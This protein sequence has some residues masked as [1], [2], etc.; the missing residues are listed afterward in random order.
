MLYK[1]NEFKSLNAEFNF[2][3]PNDPTISNFPCFFCGYPV[4]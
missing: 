2:F 3:N 4:N 1:E